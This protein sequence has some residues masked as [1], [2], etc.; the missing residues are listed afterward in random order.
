MAIVLSRWKLPEIP[1]GWHPATITHLELEKNVPVHWGMADRLHIRFQLDRDHR[2]WV[3]RY[4][5]HLS[6]SSELGR[7][8][9]GLLGKLPDGVDVCSL[10]GTRC[11]VRVEH[12]RGKTGRLWAHVVEAEPLSTPDGDDTDDVDDLFEDDEIELDQEVDGDDN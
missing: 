3:Q 7:F 8:L 9:P 1:E 5:A 4:I 2:L 10:V 11:R 12:R 6:E